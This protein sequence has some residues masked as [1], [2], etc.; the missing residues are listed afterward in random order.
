M[1]LMLLF[2]CIYYHQAKWAMREE[3]KARTV[4]SNKLKEEV[5]EFELKEIPQSIGKKQLR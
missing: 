5:S 1:L 4:S 2:G 3:I